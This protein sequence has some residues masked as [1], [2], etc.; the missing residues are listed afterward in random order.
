MFFGRAAFVR[1]NVRILAAQ[2]RVIRPVQRLQA[3]H[4]RAGPVEGE[5]NVDARP[6]MLFEFRQRR[7]RVTVVAVS[8]HVPL[9]GPRNRLRDFRMH[10]G[11]IVA[12][13]TASGLYSKPAA[14]QNNVAD[15]PRR[16]SR[17][18]GGDARGPTLTSRFLREGGY[19]DLKFPHR[20]SAEI[21]QPFARIG[22]LHLNEPMPRKRTLIPP[23]SP[24]PR[25]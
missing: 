5:E 13:K 2:H 12:G 20:S 25:A 22:A 17:A 9:I 1:I 15:W 18:A 16:S 7:P 14:Y 11:I 6:E 10:P 8:H 24:G 3:E 19:L 21:F 23:H 4:V